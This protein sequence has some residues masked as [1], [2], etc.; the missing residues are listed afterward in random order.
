MKIF[1]LENILNVIIYAFLTFIIVILV[2][3]LDLSRTNNRYYNGFYGS[4]SRKIMINAKR[5]GFRIDT[6]SLGS[7]FV[8]YDTVNDV[9]AGPSTMTHRVIYG[10]GNYPKPHMLDGHFFT[11]D[12]I[13]SKEKTCVVGSK[14]LERILEENGEKYVEAYGDKFRIIGTMGLETASDLDLI[15]IFNWGGY[16]DNDKAIL[17][18]YMIDSDFYGRADEVFNAIWAQLENFKKDHEEIEFENIYY[19]NNIRGF[20][21]YS[22]H[23]YFWATVLVAL[24]LIIVSARYSSRNIR[25]VAVNRMVGVPT[26]GIIASVASKYALTALTGVAI[27]FITICL[28][29]TNAAFAKSEFAYFAT[30]PIKTVVIV[31]I[32]AVLISVLCGIIPVL[33]ILAKKDLSNEV[34]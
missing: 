32:I 29:N 10:K 21:Y 13:I 12:E 9:Q 31:I 23:L 33:R 8:L 17:T 22:R 20:E 6:E 1:R 15:I 18:K 28:L 27:S 7:D 24:N 11:D 14:V 25:V 3:Q 34:K 19:E 30:L 4:D 2:N 16:Y 26:A 5:T